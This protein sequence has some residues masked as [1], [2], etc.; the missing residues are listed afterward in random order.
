MAQGKSAK[1]AAPPADKAEEFR[2]RG[3]FVMLLIFMLLLIILWGSVYLI[4][5]SRGMTI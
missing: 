3:T 2:P 4:L 1:T 5:L